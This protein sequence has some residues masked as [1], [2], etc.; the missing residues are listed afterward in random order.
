[1]SRTL[2]KKSFDQLGNSGVIIRCR[3]ENLCAS[4]VH[5]ENKFSKFFSINVAREFSTTFLFHF[6]WLSLTWLCLPC[7][8]IERYIR[9][10]FFHFYWLIEYSAHSAISV[11]NSP[12]IRLKHKY[13]R[14]RTWSCLFFISIF[15]HN[16]IIESPSHF[17]T[18]ELA[19]TIKYYC[20]IYVEK[21]V[22]M[23]V[24]WFYS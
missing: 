21:E 8:R 11:S 16:L 6:N 19:N 9:A 7:N 24:N 17:D 13:Q 23:Y 5:F 14:P 1:M 22:T 10:L 18:I 2:R 4:M 12:I 20:P 3:W 15:F